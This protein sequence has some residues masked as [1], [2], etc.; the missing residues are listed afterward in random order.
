MTARP[1]PEAMPVEAI[2][3]LFRALADTTRR[4]VVERLGHGPA[5][6]SDL[7]APFAM[8]LPSFVQHLR[9]LEEAGLVCSR[10]VGRVRTY[11]LD[12]R[13]L[14][15]IDTWLR[16]Q[17]DHQERRFNQLDALLALDDGEDAPLIAT[18]TTTTTTTTKPT[19]ETKPSPKRPHHDPVGSR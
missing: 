17:R 10:K 11:S 12:R 6:V 1:N 13:R 7:A 14:F 5:S 9:I 19:Q 2:D 16:Q 3:Q 18:T 8:A 4:Q 15:A